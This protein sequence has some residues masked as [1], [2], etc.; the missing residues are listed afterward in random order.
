MHAL[1]VDWHAESL[2]EAID[3]QQQQV[4]FPFMFLRLV[5]LIVFCILF[6]VFLFFVFVFSSREYYSHAC[7]QQVTLHASVLAHREK[8]AQRVPLDECLGLFTQQEQLRQEDA[9]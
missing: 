3:A 1:A 8:S 6:F 4:P 5:L 7:M 2:Q 9:W